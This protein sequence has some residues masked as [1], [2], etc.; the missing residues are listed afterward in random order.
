MARDIRT[1]VLHLLVYSVHIRFC[2]SVSRS[3]A[4]EKFLQA[5]RVR[6]GDVFSQHSL[7][8]ELEHT[9]PHLFHYLLVKNFEELAGAMVGRGVTAGCLRYGDIPKKRSALHLSIMDLGTVY[10]QLKDYVDSLALQHN[11][12]QYRVMVVSDGEVPHRKLAS[13]VAVYL[14][15]WL[16]CPPMQYRC[17]TIA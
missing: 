2:Q 12:L 5:F 14:S 13:I 11:G 9:H 3:E 8:A 4:A 10:A 1:L 6:S 17:R 15:C 16:L 7:L